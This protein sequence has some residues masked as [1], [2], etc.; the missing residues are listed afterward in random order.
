[1]ARRVCPGR[2]MRRAGLFK[3]LESLDREDL[4]GCPA[5]YAGRSLADFGRRAS[6]RVQQK[7]AQ[8]TRFMAK[9]YT[10]LMIALL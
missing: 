10:R 9:I 2:G 3:S 4:H 8:N 7:H 1:M 5:L 6:R